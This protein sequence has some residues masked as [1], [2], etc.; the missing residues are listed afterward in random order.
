MVYHRLM[1]FEPNLSM[2]FTE[3]PLLERP[4]AAASVGF[5]AAELWWPFDAADP[6]QGP[7][8]AL[9]LAFEDAGLRLACLNFFGGDFSA[10][11]R[12]ALSVPRYRDAFQANVPCAV[13]LADRLRCGTLNALYGDTTE[14]VPRE[15]AEA[16]AIDNLAG[17][18]DAARRI[19]AKVVV[20][21]LN[22]MEFP[23]YGL[24]RVA[25]VLAFL[26]RAR[27][28]RGVVAWCS[29]DMYHAAL[30]GDAVDELIERHADRFGHVQIADV[31]GRR[32]PGTGSIDFPGLLG[33]LRTQGYD[34]WVGLEYTPTSDSASSLRRTMAR[35]AS[36]GEVGANA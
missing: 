27:D 19:G 6:G 31:P 4:A 24:H 9:A 35:L 16:L 13:R 11:E 8:D 5:D 7:L 23:S 1:R 28:Q 2:L 29:F 3:L 36:Y 32:E 12:G 17:A 34:G 20:E 26:D 33:R 25:D 30:S 10:G 15:A 22:P 18:V 21:T 14:N